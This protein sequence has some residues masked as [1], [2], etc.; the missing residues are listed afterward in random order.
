M[1]P[2]VQAD[3]RAPRQAATCN[4]SLTWMLTLSVQEKL[5]HCD[6]Q[7]E[8]KHEGDDDTK[9]QEAAAPSPLSNTVPQPQTPKSPAV[10]KEGLQR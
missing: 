1:Q 5:M 10:P 9:E 3:N 2:A 6:L 8:Q 4:N 7:G